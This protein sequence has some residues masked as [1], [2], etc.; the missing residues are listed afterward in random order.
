MTNSCIEESK[1]ET[2]FRSAYLGEIEKLIAFLRKKETVTNLYHK[3]L[4]VKC[5]PL[6]W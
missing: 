4:L 1:F 3:E 6:I 5:M 2:H